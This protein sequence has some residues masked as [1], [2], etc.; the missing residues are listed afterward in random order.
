[1][2]LTRK[3]V[4]VTGGAGFLGSHLCERL[5]RDGQG[6]DAD[7]DALAWQVLHQGDESAA[8][9]AEQVV[10][11]H[12]DVGEEQLRGV[13]GVHAE[14][15]QVPAAEEAG[16]AALDHEQADP[17]VPG[18]RIGARRHDHEVAELAVR[19]ERLLPVQQVM[20]TRTDRGTAYPLQVAARP[21]L[22]HRDRRDQL[23]GAVAGEP[24]LPLLRRA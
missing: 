21:R 22:G 7:G 4:L 20:V 6:G 23:P 14:L 2:P 1:M 15:F 3:R 13:L 9:R 10:G 16:H 5:L 18:G 17:P 8:L 19:D 24:A 12:P 11:W